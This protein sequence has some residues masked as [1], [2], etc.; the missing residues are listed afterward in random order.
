ME[1][2][3]FILAL[4]SSGFPV[5]LPWDPASFVKRAKPCAPGLSSRGDNHGQIMFLNLN[6]MLIYQNRT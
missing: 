6:Y 3:T 2:R 1:F 5:V 4:Q